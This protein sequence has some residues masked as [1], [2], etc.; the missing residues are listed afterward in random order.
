M[1]VAQSFAKNFGLYGERIGASHIV[2]SEPGQVEIVTNHMKNLIRPMYSNPPMHG[3]RIV[4]A[5]LGD[6]ALE[7]E[8]RAEVK[9][10]AER[11]LFCRSELHKALVAK[12]AKGNWDH[13]LSQIGMFTF[14]GLT[15][16]QCIRLKEEYHIY[17]LENGRISMCG[18][19]TSNIEY[20]A[21][22]IV[23]VL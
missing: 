3:S 13:V 12:K 15:K 20:V 21:Q 9:A 23:D 8:W 14:T 17:L 4:A 7:K 18:L 5:L 16:E 2:C 19:N 6:P 11:I 10:V 22:S 1:V